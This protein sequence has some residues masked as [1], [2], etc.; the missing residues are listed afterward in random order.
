MRKLRRVLG[1]IGEQVEI[2]FP[3]R[4]G[5]RRGAGRKPSGPR[6]RVAHYRRESIDQHKPVHVTLRVLDS[7]RRLRRMDAYRA[8]RQAMLVAHRR[9]DFR[10][11][12]VSIQS[13]H[14]HLICEADNRRALSSGMSSLKISAAKRLNRV[15]RR[16]GAVFAD[17]YHSEI[18]A[19]PLQVRN[20]LSYVMNNWRRH[21][22]DRGRKA[23]LDVYSS[24]ISFRDWKERPGGFVCPSDHEP[25]PVKQAESWLLVK[26]WKGK[27]AISCF[28]VPGPIL[29]TVSGGDRT[30]ARA[31][32]LTH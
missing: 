19:C 18:L 27:Y 13:N 25:L 10:I 12:Q 5:R 23:C 21:G 15:L 4:G 7:I 26:G 11:V 30:H 24:A 20:C 6:R 17:R 29:P 8:I 14:V 28:E 2:A 31:L 16:S 32:D 3:R 9:T 1:R 22:E